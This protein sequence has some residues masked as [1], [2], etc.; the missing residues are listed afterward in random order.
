METKEKRREGAGSIG[1]LWFT[2]FLDLLG[3]GIIIPILPVVAKGYAVTANWGLEPDIMVG[4]VVM[5]F[6]LMQLLFSPAVGN[7]SD[8]IGRRPV[9]LFTILLSALG[10]LMFGLAGGLATLII[11]RIIAGLGAANIPTAQAYIA[12]ITAPEERA[13][14]MGL[15]GAAFGL[16]FVFGPAIGAGLIIVAKVQGWNNLLTIGIFS[17]SLSVIN[18]FLALWRLPESLKEKNP[19]SN[20]GFLKSYEGLL[21]IFR[22]PILGELFTINL[23]FITAFVLMQTNAAL[24]WKEQFNTP[25]KHIYIIFGFIGICTALVQGL[26]IKH[27]QRWLGLRRMLLL[28]TIF[29]GIGLTLLPFPSKDN[30]YL[31]T[32]MAIMCLALGNGMLMPSLNGMVSSQTSS[33]TQGKILGLFQGVGAIGRVVSPAIAGILYHIQFTFPYLVAGMLMCVC[34]VLAIRLIP[35]IAK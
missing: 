22:T 32:A 8:R 3:F 11:S 10:S 18:F 33:A 6:S 28:G 21:P 29:V 20:R 7:I 26:L 23:I 1:I 30:F 27:F 34:M 4:V 9:L 13:T 16:G 17:A 14:K 12:D 24:M 5:S 2:I 15:I 31:F 19:N 25:E 35:K